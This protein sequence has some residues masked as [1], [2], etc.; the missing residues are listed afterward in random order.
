MVRVR[1]AERACGARARLQR[2]PL[3]VLLS[4]GGELDGLGFEFHRG[5]AIWPAAHR[6]KPVR[7][8]LLRLLRFAHRA[9][10]AVRAAPD[11]CASVH[12]SHETPV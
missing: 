10:R 2:L 11:A 4:M 12:V 3:H 8:N 7:A 9:R 1:C 6:V 5:A